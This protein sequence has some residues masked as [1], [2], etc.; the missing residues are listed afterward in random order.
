MHDQRKAA[1]IIDKITSH[2]TSTFA[3][4]PE[5]IAPFICKNVDNEFVFLLYQICM[6]G[7]YSVRAVCVGFFFCVCVCTAGSGL[8]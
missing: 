2:F 8:V 6:G 5:H 7:A 3:C 1:I 4:I